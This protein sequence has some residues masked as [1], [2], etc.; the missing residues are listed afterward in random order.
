MIATPI[1][2][3]TLVS[4]PFGTPYGTAPDDAPGRTGEG[5]G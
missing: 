3:I 2:F 1:P 5:K 4:P